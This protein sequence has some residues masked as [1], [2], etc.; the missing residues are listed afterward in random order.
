[1][2]YWGV[3]F[4]L[5]DL[6]ERIVDAAPE[7]LALVA[8]DMRLPYAELDTRA[9]RLATLLLLDRGSVC[10]NSGGEKI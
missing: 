4:N 5:A 1:V 2:F 6:F 10:V 9:N 3:E 7:R 8:G